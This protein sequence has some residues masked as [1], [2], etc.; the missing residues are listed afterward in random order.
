MLLLSRCSSCAS[1]VKAGA[2]CPPR[3]PVGAG[4]YWRPEYSA[5]LGQP[6]VPVFGVSQQH[7]LRWW[8]AAWR[9]GVRPGWPAGAEILPPGWSLGALIAG[10]A[11]NLQKTHGPHA[12]PPTFRDMFH[13]K[14]QHRPN[15]IWQ[16]TLTARAAPKPAKTGKILG[17]I[18]RYDQRRAH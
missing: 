16:E 10:P 9:C 12:S 18:L 4:E 5:K 8:C 14:H 7:P 2:H 11:P 3:G 6:Y 17:M 13:V 15:R 1:G